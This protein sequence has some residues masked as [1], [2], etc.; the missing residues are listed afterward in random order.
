LSTD[1][2]FPSD[3]E[4]FELIKWF[5]AA[6]G[7]IVDCIQRRDYGSGRPGLEAS[8]RFTEGTEVTPEALLVPLKVLSDSCPGVDRLMVE[9]QG[10]SNDVIGNLAIP[11]NQFR[12]YPGTGRGGELA[13]LG[14]R[15]RTLTRYTDP[16]NLFYPGLSPDEVYEEYLLKPACAYLMRVFADCLEVARME[17]K[18]SPD[19]LSTLECEIKVLQ[20]MLAS[21]EPPRTHCHLHKAAMR[22]TLIANEFTREY[23][24]R[25]RRKGQEET[26]GLGAMLREAA[27]LQVELVQFLEQTDDK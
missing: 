17:H 20:R 14:L 7:I 27:P 8:A 25:M 11:T 2:G 3:Y 5:F 6:K 13:L 19:L 15:Y 16:R 24:L 18:P 9:L 12:D 10:D 1:I 26:K 22:V 21:N 23:Q 4:R